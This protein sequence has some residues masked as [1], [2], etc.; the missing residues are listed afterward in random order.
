LYGYKEPI[1][2]S[3]IKQLFIF[4][5]ENPIPGISLD[6]AARDEQPRGEHHEERQGGGI[7]SAI[8]QGNPGFEN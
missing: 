7:Y 1:T 4:R 6:M 5:S 8:N 3:K 2:I